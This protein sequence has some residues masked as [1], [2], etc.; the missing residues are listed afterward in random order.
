MKK[1][2][3]GSGGQRTEMDDTIERKTDQVLQTLAA[4]KAAAYVDQAEYAR[5]LPPMGAA[6]MYHLGFSMGWHEPPPEKEWPAD[7]P[8]PTAWDT[9]YLLFLACL[10][11]NVTLS[12]HYAPKILLSMHLEIGKVQHQMEALAAHEWY[13]TIPQC[14]HIMAWQTY[15]EHWHEDTVSLHS[16]IRKRALELWALEIKTERMWDKPI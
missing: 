1:P 6:L 12:K 15:F 10:P 2:P 7:G 9:D 8:L 11:C 13:N 14:T 16:V 4:M 3:W 5:R